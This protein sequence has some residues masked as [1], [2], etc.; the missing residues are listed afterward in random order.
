MQILL[1]YY[2]SWFVYSWARGYKMHLNT[3]VLKKDCMVRNWIKTTFNW[4]YI[5]SRFFQLRKVEHLLTQEKMRIFVFAGF[6]YNVSSF[7]YYINFMM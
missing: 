7:A 3:Y 1:H 2:I 5:R 4:K 6:M